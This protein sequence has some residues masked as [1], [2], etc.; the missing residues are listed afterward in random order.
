QPAHDDR[1]R[2]AHHLHGTWGGV[3]WPRRLGRHAAAARDGGMRRYLYALKDKLGSSRF[4]VRDLREHLQG[5]AEW[6]LRAQ[7][8][9]PDDGVAH[10]YDLRQGTWHASYPETTGYIIPTLYDYA[11]YHGVAGYAEAAYRMA[12]WEAKI[13]LPDGAVR[14]GHMDAEVV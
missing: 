3:A 12:V 10:S 11:R 6:L 14:A 9:T 4:P 8:A 5:A 2:R 7:R 13:Q 1:R